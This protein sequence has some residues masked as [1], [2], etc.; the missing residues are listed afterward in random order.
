[1]SLTFICQYLRLLDSGQ[2]ANLSASIYLCLA[3]LC[4]TLKIYSI[5][6][7]PSF[8]PH[9]L[10]TYQSDNVIKNELLLTSIIACLSKLVRTLCNYLTPYLPDIIKR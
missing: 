5:A 9:V 6:E 10:Q 8:M 3:E 1:M 2:H 7:L 4:A